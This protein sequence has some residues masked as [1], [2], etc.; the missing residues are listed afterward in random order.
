MV[1]GA[2]NNRVGF[3]ANDATFTRSRPA[4]R[5][6][7]G[8]FFSFP[9]FLHQKSFINEN[10]WCYY[11]LIVAH[12]HNGRLAIGFVSLP[13]CQAVGSESTNFRRRYLW[14]LLFFFYFLLPNL[15]M[16]LFTAFLIFLFRL[17]VN[18]PLAILFADS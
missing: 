9:L 11:C 8:P 7:P 16:N 4:V 5:F 3:S 18:I 1:K 10:C 17:K 13:F 2:S 6:R 15:A 12:Q 14:R